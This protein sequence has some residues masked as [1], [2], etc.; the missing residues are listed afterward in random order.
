MDYLLNNTLTTYVSTFSALARKLIEVQQANLDETK[1]HN[2]KMEEMLQELID[3]K[4]G[5]E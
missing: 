3:K 2:Q 4:G 5:N 1:R